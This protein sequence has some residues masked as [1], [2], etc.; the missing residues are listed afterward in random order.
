MRGLNE[1]VATELAVC[2]A[3]SKSISPKPA[4]CVSGLTLPSASR[5]KRVCRAEKRDSG[6]K[7]FFD[8][9]YGMK[10]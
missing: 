5:L 3:P 6:V 1:L 2:A 7:K 10:L 8:C 9:R 4:R